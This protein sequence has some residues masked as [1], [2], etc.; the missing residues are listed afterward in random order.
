MHQSDDVIIIITDI[1]D[2]ALVDELLKKHNFFVNNYYSFGL[3]LG[4]L[5]PTLD[6]IGEN[7]RGD[8]TRCLLE[9]LKAWLKQSD[10][11]QKNGGC[12][13]TSLVNALRK[14]EENA[15]ANRIEYGKI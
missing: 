9:V 5:A 15:V 2:L 11:V 4:L 3:H 7:H 14:V 6:S 12:T 10:E 1:S 8:G 13:I